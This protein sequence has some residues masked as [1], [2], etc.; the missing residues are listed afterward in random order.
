MYLYYEYHNWTFITACIDLK[1][2]NYIVA[3]FLKLW[4]SVVIKAIACYEM[5]QAQKEYVDNKY[6][7][8]EQN[9]IYKRFHINVWQRKNEDSVRV[10]KLL[11]NLNY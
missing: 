10:F 8:L 3:A 11:E 5:S 2:T 6:N 4:L 9:K 1:Q 7:H